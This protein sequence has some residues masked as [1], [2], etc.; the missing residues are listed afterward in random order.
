MRRVQPSL[1]LLAEVAMVRY[2]RAFSLTEMILVV[3]FIGIF[4]AISLPRM[5]FAIISKSKVGYVAQKIVTDLR[6]TRQLAISDAATNTRGYEL[7]M[8]GGTPYSSYQIKNRDGNR[9]IDTLTID[10]AVSCSGDNRFRF[11]PLGNLL[12]SNDDELVISAEGKTITISL[13]TATG[14]VKC[15]EN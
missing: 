13:E 3:L 8:V 5:N 1:S 11:G 6:R 15:V 9:L 2:K 7:R 10:T 14:M 12:N 4:A